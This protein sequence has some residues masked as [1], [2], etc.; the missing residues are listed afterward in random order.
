MASATPKNTE[1]LAELARDQ[2]RPELVAYAG[3][4]RYQAVATLYWHDLLKDQCCGD[5]D[6]FETG[7]REKTVHV[8]GP[9][10]EVRAKCS[11]QIQAQVYRGAQG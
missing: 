6:L 10:S 5:I 7:R 1:E 9:E 2:Q 3:N 11:R 4:W 8:H